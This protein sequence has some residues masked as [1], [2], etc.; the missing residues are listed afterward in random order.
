M[1]QVLRANRTAP[2]LEPLRKAIKEGSKDPDDQQYELRDGLLFFQGRLEVPMEPEELRAKLI[3]HIHAQPSTA[4]PGINKTKL[5][6]ARRFHWKSLG[7][8]IKTF[9]EH[10]KCVRSKARRDKTPGFLVPLPIP[11]R[12]NQHLTM[13]YKDFPSDGTY[14]MILVIMDRLAKRAISIPRV[15]RHAMQKSLL[16]R[17]PFTGYVTL[18]SQTPLYQTEAPNSELPSR[19]KCKG[20][21]VPRSACQQPTTQR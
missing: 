1:D 15:T 13:D 4:H 16:G 9:T 21:Q 10:C 3:I 6:I 14:D 20:S 7:P 19:E 5:L 8:D 2:V 12:P 11:A 17:L 18:V